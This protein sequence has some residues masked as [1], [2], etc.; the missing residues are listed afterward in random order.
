MKIG[1][2]IDWKIADWLSSLPEDD[3]LAQHF[4]IR[5]YSKKMDKGLALWYAKTSYELHQDISRLRGGYKQ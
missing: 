4:Y 1:S 3:T 2:S 5:E